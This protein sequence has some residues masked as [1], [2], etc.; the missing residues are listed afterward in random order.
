[1]E[2]IEVK[3]LN[4]D[5]D[6]IEDKLK[7]IGAKKIFKKLYR[8]RVFDYPDLR[9]NDQGAWI[10]VRDEGDKTTITFKKRIGMKND[11]KMRDDSMEEVELEVSDFDKMAI[12]FEKIGLKQKFYEEN[13][14]TRYV[15]G[16]IEFDIDQWPMLPPYLEIEAKSWDE[17]EKAIMLLKLNPEDKKICS[18]MQLYEDIGINELDYSEITFEK[19]VKVKTV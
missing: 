13:W 15:L 3:Y 1:M 8:R 16:D 17:I 6:L 11:D 4:I 2:E 7:K 14:R 10:R 5:I 18:T 12:F 19:M 9:L